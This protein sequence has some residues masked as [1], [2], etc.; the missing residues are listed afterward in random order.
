[1][2]I[3]PLMTGTNMYDVVLINSKS[4]NTFEHLKVRGIGAH[5]IAHQARRMGMTAIVLDFIESWKK[6][7]FTKAIDKFVSKDTKII[8]FSLTWVDNTTNPYPD[9]YIGNYINNQNINFMLD[10]IK[11]KS[12]DIKVI[13]GG[14]KTLQLYHMLSDIV[15]YFFD[16]YS[17]TQFADF[18]S[19]HKI[20][21]K[22]IDYDTEAKGR[23]DYDFK[24]ANN[25]YMPESHITHRETLGLE[26]SR[27]C[28]FSCKFCSFPLI[29][30]KDSSSYIKDRDTLK[31][32]LIYNY[33]N[34][35][36]QKYS[37]QDDTFNDSV[38]K[39]EYFANMIA[40]LPFKTYFWC[41]LRA[42][43]MVTNPEMIPMLHSMGLTQTWFGVETLTQKAG[44]IIGKG[45]DPE[46]IKEMLQA[47]R[48]QW[49][50]DVNIQTGYIVGLP[51][52][53]EDDIVKHSEWFMAPECPVH[54][55]LYTPL[56]IRPKALTEYF[57]T[58]E[59]SEFDRTY[60]Q[61]GFV[62]PLESEFTGSQA[63]LDRLN[64]FYYWQRDTQTEI[65]NY[66]DA[67][68]LANRMNDAMVDIRARNTVNLPVGIFAS[69]HDDFAIG[70]SNDQIR[71]MPQSKL[72][73]VHGRSNFDD[74]IK[75]WYVNK[76]LDISQ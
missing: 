32:E 7:D 60:D 53:T 54:E 49:Q 28:R 62:F 17:E 68:K 55:V 21:N 46:R 15:D 36:V 52:E 11:Q 74:M 20:F 38:E 10:T 47:C 45:M 73:L 44:K 14:K 75:R 42:E 70:L 61:Y 37:I 13:A 9:D 34:F 57:N 65:P 48:D 16:G 72:S 29:G 27:G 24:Y 4:S 63:D 25:I 76:L 1:M 3:L 35:G 64:H 5:L 69:S 43:M 22:V 23:E 19:E 58:Q 67:L 51:G 66:M 8:G 26:L 31:A 56:G 39:V 2:Q 71:S 30:R 50:N 59:I 18:I 6:E 12:P 40:T 41:Y 33:E